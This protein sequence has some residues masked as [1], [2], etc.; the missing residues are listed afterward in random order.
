MLMGRIRV[1]LLFAL[2]SLFILVNC[3]FADSEIIHVPDTDLSSAPVLAAGEVTEKPVQ[4][5]GNTAAG[6]EKNLLWIRL[7]PLSYTSEFP[8][9]SY[10]VDAD[11]IRSIKGY[12]EISDTVILQEELRKDAL[13]ISEDGKRVLLAHNHYLV[14]GGD[15]I[16]EVY[17]LE[18]QKTLYQYNAGKYRYDFDSMSTSP[19][20]E[21]LL[22]PTGKDHLLHV[23]VNNNKETKI[24]TFPNGLISPDGTKIAARKWGTEPGKIVV[25][26]RDAFTGKPQEEFMFETDYNALYLTQWH[27]SGKILFYT[28][29]G[30]FY[31]DLN[32]KKIVQVGSY[33]Y[34]PYMSPDGRYVAYRRDQ[35]VD[36]IGLYVGTLWLYKDR[37]Y[38]DGLYVKDLVTGEL[39][40]VAQMLYNDFQSYC[41]KPLQWI[42]TDK[43][44]DKLANRYIV[45]SDPGVKLAARSSLFTNSGSVIDNDVST[46]GPESQY[47]TCTAGD[48]VQI[49]KLRQVKLP[50][51]EEGLAKYDCSTLY[52]EPMKLKGI[53]IINGY[54]K[55]AQ[56]YREY[57]RARKVQVIFSNGSSYTFDLKNNTTGFQTLNFGKVVETRDVTIKILSV[58]PGTK[59]ADT[60]M[61]VQLIEAP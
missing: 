18:Q 22:L 10:F 26:I 52:T 24:Y 45:S 8:Q 29:E 20:M 23:D 49:Y 59:Y 42:R 33:Y 47:Y 46:R 16:L 61:E 28:Y 54:A 40:Q 2:I 60:F 11:D 53:K 55:S 36:G 15:T 25:Q 1:F 31:Y 4:N 17:D 7:N 9:I 14:D 43:D 3:V 58:Y 19:N 56:T 41:M 32:T 27:S 48:W 51:S 13:R 34:E 12:Y 21:Y 6:K 38:K 35:D 30:S 44:F 50:V 57:S 37:G 39:I 5:A